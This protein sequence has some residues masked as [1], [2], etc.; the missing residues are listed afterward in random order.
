[1]IEVKGWKYVY[2]KTA[3]GGYRKM[4]VKKTTKGKY[5]VRVVGFRNRHD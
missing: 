3:K 5:L 4:K 1:V 2:R